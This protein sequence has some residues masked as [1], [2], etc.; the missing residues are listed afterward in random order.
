MSIFSN[1]CFFFSVPGPLALNLPYFTTKGKTSLM[2]RSSR[3]LLCVDRI[4][5]THAENILLQSSHLVT[6]VF[7][8]FW[9]ITKCIIILIS[10]VSVITVIITCTVPSSLH[11][12]QQ[13]FSS[14]SFGFFLI[15]N[16]KKMF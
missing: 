14:E 5:K 16:N 7:L 3:L 6:G 2:G 12:L 9:I 13:M 1:L 4:A 8:H 10:T 15:I 11:L